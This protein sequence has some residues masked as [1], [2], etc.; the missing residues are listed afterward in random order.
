MTVA[1]VLVV[2]AAF[3]FSYVRVM[4]ARHAHVARRGH[5]RTADV[6]P[7]RSTR[8]LMALHTPYAT[9]EDTVAT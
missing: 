2:L 5:D 6:H 9:L 8:G 1:L 3:G 4:E 7:A